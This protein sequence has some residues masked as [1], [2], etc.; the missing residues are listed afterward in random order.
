MTHYDGLLIRTMTDWIWLTNVGLGQDLRP[1][2]RPSTRHSGQLHSA[3]IHGPGGH[4]EFAS[5]QQQ[6]RLRNLRTVGNGWEWS[7]KIILKITENHIGK[8]HP[9][10]IHSLRLAPV[11]GKHAASVKIR[12]QP[13]FY[14]ETF[15]EIKG[16]NRVQYQIWWWIA[17]AGFIVSQ[18]SWLWYLV[19]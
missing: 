4:R 14:G 10:P 1:L 6:T 11:F 12:S 15:D 9:I 7:F 18:K 13:T 8:N 3:R 17:N 5:W 2:T 19:V 16:M